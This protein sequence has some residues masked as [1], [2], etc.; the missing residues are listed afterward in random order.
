MNAGVAQNFFLR[1]IDIEPEPARIGSWFQF[2]YQSRR[3]ASALSSDWITFLFPKRIVL[4]ED[5]IRT[6]RVR[7]VWVPWRREDELVPF[8]RVSSLRHIRGFF[9][10]SV[11]IE[12]SGGNNN[13]D[14]HGLNKA[15]ADVLVAAINKTL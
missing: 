6:Q 5:G 1:E 15:E 3:M 8:N 7:S 2:S 14:I 12:T 4:S 11:I 13:L 9:W 10:D